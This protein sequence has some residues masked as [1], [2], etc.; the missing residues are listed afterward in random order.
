MCASTISLTLQYV[1][2]M[3]RSLEYSTPTLLY[4]TS[5]R[6]TYSKSS[7]CVHTHTW[8]ILGKKLFYMLCFD[9]SPFKLLFFAFTLFHSSRYFVK[10]I[11][12]D[13]FNADSWKKMPKETSYCN[14]SIITVIIMII[15]VIILLFS[16]QALLI[17]MRKSQ[18]H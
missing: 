11:L 17:T 5:L 8:V 9:R 18:T 16:K 3:L 4:Y 15:I 6:Y 10:Y 13:F 12:V 1:G 14:Q 7:G 2:I